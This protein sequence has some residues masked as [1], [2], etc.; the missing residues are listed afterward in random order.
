MDAHTTT[1]ERKLSDPDDD[2]FS[3]IK[4]LDKPR[5]LP[6]PVQLNF[7]HL[8]EVGYDLGLVDLCWPDEIKPLFENRTD[9]PVRYVTHTQKERTLLLYTKN[10]RK[11]FIHLYP[12]RKPLLLARDNECGVIKMVCTTIRPT[13]IPYPI[14]GSWDTSAAF[15]SDHI[16]YETLEKHP[17][18]LPDHLYS[19][20]TT[21]LRQ[22]GHCF[23]IATVLCS[24]LLGVGYDA[25]VVSGYADRDIA[26]RIMVRQDCPFPAFKEEEEKPPERPKIEKYAITPP[27]DYKSKFLTM[28]E[29]RERD[30]LLK[31]DEESAEKERLRLLE[32]E[33]PPVD[34]L[35]GTRVHAWVLV[36][37]GSKNIT[38]SFFIEPSTGTMYPIDSR[39]Y[40]GIE[41]VWNH[42]NYWVNLQD[43]SKGLGALDYDLRKNN[44]W[45]HLLAGEPYEL[46]V[47]KERE[48]GDEDTSRD[49]FIEKHLDMPAPWPMRLHIES[50]RFSRRFPGGDV[51]TNYKRVI[52][53]QKAPFASP[54]GL[55]SRITRYKDFACT[56]PFLLEEEYSNRKDKY[57]RTIYEYATGVQKDYFAS[58]REDALVKHVFNKGDYSFYA[59]RTLI[60]NHALR[61]DNLYKMVVEQD[62]IME[63]FRNRPDKL[64]FRQTNI[65]KEDAEKR[66]A[67]LFKHN[68]HSFLQ[69]YE[70]Q[71]D[72]PSHEDIASRE[73]AIKDREIRLKYH[74][75]QNNIT[76]ST[77]IFMKPAVTEW[78]DDLDFTSDLTYGYQAEVN[79]T[80]PRQVE[81]FQMFHFH[82]NEENICMSTYRTMEA[83]LE[84]FL[85]TRLENLKNPELD[86]P[87]FNK[88][89]NAAH[90]ENML[91]NEERKNMLMKKEIEDSHIDFLAPY[92]VKYKLPL[93]AQQARLAKAECLKEYKE[94]LVNR[95]NRLYDNYKMLD[96]E[97]H[98]LNDYYAE[99]RD[100]LSEAEELRHFD[101]ISRIVDSMKL[102]QKRADRHKALSKSRYKK[103]EMILAKHPLLAVLR[104]TSVKP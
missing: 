8:K 37:A 98:V 95:A 86:V 38:E 100:S 96:E 41:S 9:F 82:L 85:A 42:Q 50:E 23:E 94:L 34:E 75:G 72:R 20:H 60:F 16:T 93:G 6:E 27:N 59:C 104:R 57:C 14:F 64:M 19:P 36:R 56:D 1:S 101:E 53:Q 48:L 26:L 55:V 62:K 2:K 69:K 39:K 43:C 76:A 70:R 89:Q 25:L 33:K 22:K 73:F 31:K 51:T 15:F 10:F 97:L 68:I 11:K 21:L 87:I 78:G 63:Y 17:Q 67:N 81:L 74:Y 88:E 79:V 12:D 99:R 3:Y 46:R 24:A 65:V 47:Q 18:K 52:V 45:I 77:R 7:Q 71:E 102:I 58:G 49:C 28:M 90:R 40:F 66:V 13:A 84:K 30:K 5:D 103:L 54:D 61:G 32:E 35:Q 29:Q 91:R 4:L 80:L 44:K 83:Y 92:V